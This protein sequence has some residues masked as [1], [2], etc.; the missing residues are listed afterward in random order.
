MDCVKKPNSV[1][2]GVTTEENPYS[3]RNLEIAEFFDISFLKSAGAF[4]CMQVFLV[5][6]YL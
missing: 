4:L 6:S 1:K 5:I 3:F 2:D